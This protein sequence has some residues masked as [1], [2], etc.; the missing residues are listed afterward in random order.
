MTTLSAIERQM[1]IKFALKAKGQ[2]LAGFARSENVAAATVSAIAA[3]K[4]RSRR[5]EITIASATGFL[6]HELWPQHY[7]REDSMTSK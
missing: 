7:S 2:T 5:I 4:A 1:L 3:G 6:P